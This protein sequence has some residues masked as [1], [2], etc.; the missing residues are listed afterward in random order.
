MTRE[1]PETLI[2]FI[3][4]KPVPLVGAEETRQ[5]VERLLVR[6]MGYDKAQVAV[7]TPLA[8]EVKGEPYASAIDLVIMVE[9]RPFMVVKCAPGSLA[10]REREVVAAARLVEG[11]PA[12]LAIVTD[13]K[14][15]IVLDAATGK[16]RG[17]GLVAIPAAKDAP[18]LLP[19]TPPAPLSE[20][21]LEKERLIF[22][23]YDSDYVNVQRKL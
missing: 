18:G 4:G 6:E 19:D 17:Q 1:S 7:D 11:G 21:R 22:R 15:A 5:A 2:D 16:K 12:A 9:G 23:T 13:G 10:S 3:T 8:F 14:D 20:K